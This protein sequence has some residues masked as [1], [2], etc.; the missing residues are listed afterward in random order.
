MDDFCAIAAE[1]GEPQEVS[2]KQELFEQLST[3]YL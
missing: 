2:E 3:M 1:S